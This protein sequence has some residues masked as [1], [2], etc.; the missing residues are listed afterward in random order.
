MGP[1]PIGPVS[2]WEEKETPEDTWCEDTARR[3]PHQEPDLPAS[4]CGTPGLQNREE[5][6][7][8]SPCRLTSEHHLGADA[9]PS[10]HRRATV[11]LVPTE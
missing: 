8:G 5:T 7:C 1:D 6:V 4:S 3:S 9:P 10:G 2:A 11:S